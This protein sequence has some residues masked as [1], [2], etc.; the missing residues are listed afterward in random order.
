MHAC[1]CIEIYTHPNCK[2][3][4]TH[5]HTHARTHAHAQ[6]P[7]IIMQTLRDNFYVNLVAFTTRSGVDMGRVMKTSHDDEKV[8]SWVGERM[9]CMACMVFFCVLG[10]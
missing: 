6:C 1:L 7:P 8:G 4:H 5:T 3:T 9:G 10:V 2:F